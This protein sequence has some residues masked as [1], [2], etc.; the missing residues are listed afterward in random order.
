MS[1][2]ERMAYPLSNTDLNYF[3]P[4]VPITMYARFAEEPPLNTVVDAKG[5]GL[6]L[7]VS[8][9]EGDS[10]SGHWLAILVRPHEHNVLLYDPYGGKRDPWGLNHG[11][12]RTK[13]ALS[14]LGETRPLLVPYF[15]RHGLPAVF[16]VTRDQRMA[17]TIGTCGRHCVVRLWNA[18]VGD[19]EYDA[20]I[21]GFADAPD[22]VVTQLTDGADRRAR[23]E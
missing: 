8:T 2:A 21:H 13:Q 5:R 10:V 6:V 18:A 14:E 23:A 3:L 12:V 19:D 1:L 17:K 9:E 15:A 7:F 22:V 11:F 20:W 4:G 16:N